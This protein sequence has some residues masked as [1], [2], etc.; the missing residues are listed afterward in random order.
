MKLL[1]AIK[2]YLEMPPNGSKVMNQD[3][4]EFTRSMTAVEKTAAKAELRSYG[5]DIED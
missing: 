2:K 1:V 5:M 3:M 4:L